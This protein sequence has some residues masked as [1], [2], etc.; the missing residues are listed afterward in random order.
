M[1]PHISFLLEIQG[2]PDKAQVRNKLEIVFDN[3]VPDIKLSVL[4]M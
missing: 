3:S 1:W 4:C 2:R